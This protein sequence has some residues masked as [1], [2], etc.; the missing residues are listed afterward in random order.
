M[1]VVLELVIAL[2][3]DLAV[4]AGG[5]PDLGA[6]PASA[7]AAFDFG[8][9]G[10]STAMVLFTPFTLLDFTLYHLEHIRLDDGLVVIFY[11][12]LWDSPS[13]TLVFLVS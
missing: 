3:D 8:G 12:I 9:K 11:I 10:V 6:V 2:P 13:L 7:V 1:L 4:F 5:V